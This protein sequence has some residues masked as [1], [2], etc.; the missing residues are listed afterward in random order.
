MKTKVSWPLLVFI[1]VWLMVG[2]AT[3]T[4]TLVGPVR[5]I[6]STLRASSW[7]ER[8]NV[9]MI[10]VILAYVAGSFFLSRWLVGCMRR[11]RTNA[12]R[13]SVPAIA[14]VAA[15]M[16]L[17]G[18]MNPA[19][20]AQAAGSAGPRQEL[21]I[22]GGGQFVF[23]PYPDRAR[24]AE[25]KKQGFVGVV[26]LQHPAVL[27]FEPK[28]IAREK[29]NAA[30]LGLKFINA[31][32]LPWVSSNE[33]SLATIKTLARSKSAGR[34]YIHCGLG[35]DRTNVVRRMLE[36]MGAAVT[37]TSDTPQG[38]TF[39]AR[40]AVLGDKME[41]GQFRQLEDG[42]WL[43]PFPNEH[44]LYGTMLAGQAAHV[45]LLL[46]PADPQ[47]A[48]WLQE[49]RTQFE[50][51]GIAW[52]QRTLRGGDLR[53][54]EKIAAAVAGLPHPVAVVVPFMRPQPNSQV[55]DTLLLAYGGMAV[56]RAAIR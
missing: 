46:D 36:R 51:H 21:S 32:M 35:R 27:P 49:A 16:S 22:P 2:F 11:A 39:E 19:V 4:A 33:E 44:E 24:L 7:R 15:G 40:R 52:S 28:G 48:A 38:L 30:E 55:G 12:F 56:K 13:Y 20:Y 14:T 29:Q 41:R 26:S 10:L 45:L 25:L 3:G 5:W 23:G 8:E 6:T 47:Q 50:Q 1:Y 53:E 43:I 18:W 17:W 9:V 42:V 37:A 31:P 34:Y 54:A